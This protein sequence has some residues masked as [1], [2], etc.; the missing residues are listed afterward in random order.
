M[1]DLDPIGSMD[2]VL[3]DIVAGVQARPPYPSSPQQ[4]WRNKLQ[5]AIK[6]SVASRRIILTGSWSHGTPIAG[7][8]DVDHFV[9]LRGER[10]LSSHAAL[11]QLMDTFENNLS[12]NSDISLSVPTVSILDPFD[13]NTLEY[14]P[15][16]PEEGGSYWIPGIG[17]EIWLLSDPVAHITF[18]NR[19]DR[20]SSRARMLI[21]L[22]KAWK[23]ANGAQ[24]ASLYLEMFTARLLLEGGT[25][26]YLDDL[27][28]VLTV[29][30]RG[31]LT[32]IPDPSASQSRF[33]A[34]LADE[35]SSADRELALLADSID[36]LHRVEAA[37]KGGAADQAELYLREIFRFGKARHA[38][39]NSR[40]FATRRDPT[41]N[42][43]AGVRAESP[44]AS[45]YS[46]D[47]P[48]GK[49]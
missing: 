23:Y 4:K 5:V 14:A 12:R 39:R 1:P 36:R 10:P 49:L 20:A 37:A 2:R 9:V 32:E 35:T 34:A 15:A 3:S 43:L 28:G 47:S 41:R 42:Y 8:S 44:R 45:R 46:S 25:G 18:I 11:E 27:V 33:I 17:E 16:Y 22:V 26:R 30:L 13:G 48:R 31:R 29:M 6:G 7:F 21:R 19:A 40:V 38:D 24:I